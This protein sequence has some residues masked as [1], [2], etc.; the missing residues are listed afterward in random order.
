MT[1]IT[2]RVATTGYSG[3]RRRRT[4]SSPPL[5]IGNKKKLVRGKIRIYTGAEEV[6]KPEPRT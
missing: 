4:L 1:S 5:I 3:S 2:L 6:R